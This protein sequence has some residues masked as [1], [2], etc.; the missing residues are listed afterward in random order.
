MTSEP[1]HEIRNRHVHNAVLAVLY[2]GSA[3]CGVGV[4][5]GC[6]PF[7]DSA[8]QGCGAVLLR[9]HVGGPRVPGCEWALSGPELW[10]MLLC[11]LGGVT[12]LGAVLIGTVLRFVLR[13]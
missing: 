8:S 2:S 5:L 7:T 3:M 9:G 13:Q 11:S 1:E 10:V 6:V 4:V 12:V